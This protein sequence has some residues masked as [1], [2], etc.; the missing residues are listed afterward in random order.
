[1]HSCLRAQDAAHR[2]G[3][4]RAAEGAQHHHATEP[5]GNVLRL[6]WHVRIH[7]AACI[8]YES[9]HECNPV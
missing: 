3:V 2:E 6:T 1:M 4:A 8:G 7:A 5:G 9:M